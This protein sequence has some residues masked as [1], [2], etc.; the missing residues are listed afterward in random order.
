[1]DF[2]GSFKLYVVTNVLRAVFNCF[3]LQIYEYFLLIL[4]VGEWKDFN[5]LLL[6]CSW[7][8]KGFLVQLIYSLYLKLLNIYFKTTSCP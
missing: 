7:V 5:Y 2:Y 3:C 8:F 4:I 6:N 1:M